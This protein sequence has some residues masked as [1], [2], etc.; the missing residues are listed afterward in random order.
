MIKIFNEGK[1]NESKSIRVDESSGALV[2]DEKS[3]MSV[4][5]QISFN[6]KGEYGAIE[7]Y[8]KLIDF[9]SIYDDQEGV[10]I[11]KDIIS[12]EKAHSEKLNKILMKYDGNIPIED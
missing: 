10:D 11:I 8:N 1:I 5:S 3:K 9:L 4:A 6:I 12:D 2:V 7:D